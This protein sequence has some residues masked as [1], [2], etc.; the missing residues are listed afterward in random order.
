MTLPTCEAEPVIPNLLITYLERHTYQHSACVST[1]PIPHDQGSTSLLL[2]QGIQSSEPGSAWGHIHNLLGTGPL[3]LR[4]WMGKGPR[5]LSAEL[6]HF[7][8]EAHAGG[9]WAV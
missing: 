5:V 2:S 3:F 8:P 9:V 6:P 4:S 1:F 7:S